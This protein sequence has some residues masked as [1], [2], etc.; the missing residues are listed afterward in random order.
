VGKDPK[1]KR[2]AKKKKKKKRGRAD[3]PPKRTLTTLKR[4][5]VKVS[6]RGTKNTKG[7]E[8][9]KKGI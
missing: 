9:N 8:N 6:K 1:G 4:E 2:A 5:K 3:F 7:R